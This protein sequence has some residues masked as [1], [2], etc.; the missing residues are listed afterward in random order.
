MRV[1]GVLYSL[2]GDHLGSV[3]L[4]TDEDGD[5]VARRLYRPYG[6]TR[7]VTG[8]LT[9]VY[10]YTGQ[11]DAAAVGLV[12]MHARW[13]HPSLMRWIS[14]DTI[15]PDKG[16]P[17]ALNRYT[18]VRGDPVHYVDPSGHI[19]CLDDS[20]QWAEDPVTGEVVWRGPGEPPGPYDNLSELED[21]LLD[22][23]SRN[24]DSQVVRE[25]YQLNGSGTIDSQREAYRRWIS[26]VKTGGPWDF[27]DM[28]VEIWGSGVWLQSGGWWSY[29]VVANIHYGYVGMAA[30]FLEVELLGGAGAF[31]LKDHLVDPLSAGQNPRWEAIGPPGSFFDDPQDAAAIQVGIDLYNSQ[32]NPYGAF[33]REEFRAAFR[34]HASHLKRGPA[35][36]GWGERDPL[37]VDYE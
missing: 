7:Y 9:T 36:E 4:T 31:Q 20:C 13:Y 33:T 5:L 32:E 22:A 16:D 27:K 21:W 26:Q 14:A 28:V 35:P 8:T 19:A 12:Y 2:H 34:A 30:G 1:A 6:A 3:T 18:Y 25:I 24:A 11:R 10:A 15:V 29:E 17:Q 23:M 37:A